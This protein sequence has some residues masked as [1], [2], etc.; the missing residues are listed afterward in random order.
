VV[1]PECV[2]GCMDNKMSVSV[3]QGECFLLDNKK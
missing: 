3:S 1:K 2:E